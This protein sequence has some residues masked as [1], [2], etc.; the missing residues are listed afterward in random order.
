MAMKRLYKSRIPSCKYGF[1]NGKEANFINHEYLTDI[2]GEIQ[3]LD[4]EIALGHPTLYIDAARKEIDVDGR[5]PIEEIKA[6]A[7]A[8]YI[9]SQKAAMNP[10]NDRGKTA[11]EKLKTATSANVSELLAGSTGGSTVVATTSST[12]AK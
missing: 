10:A 5:D 1:K 4:E 11:L 6:K 9:A 8:E 12:T 3:E 7:I 2:P